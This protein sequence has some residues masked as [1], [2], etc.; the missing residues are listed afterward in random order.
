MGLAAVSTYHEERCKN[1]SIK[2]QDEDYKKPLIQLRTLYDRGLT[3]MNTW[4]DG[5]PAGPEAWRT[6]LRNWQKNVEACLRKHFSN[7]Y[8]EKFRD[9]KITVDM[10]NKQLSEQDKREKLLNQQIA[11]IH[12]L[13]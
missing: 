1:T 12:D 7:T 11:L 8:A 13:I 6:E 2:N 3:L 5:H 9:I 4:E 10:I